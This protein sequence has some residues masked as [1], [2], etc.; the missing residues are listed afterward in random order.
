MNHI[1]LK[2]KTILI[3]G[4]AGFIGANLVMKLIQTGEPMKIVGLDNMNDYYDVSLKEYRLAEIEKLIAENEQVDWWFIKGDLADKE[5]IDSTFEDYQFDIV[6]NLAA[7][8]GVRYSITNPDAYINSNIIGFYN[9]L[10]AIRRFRSQQMIRWTTRFR[11]M[12]QR[13]RAM[14]FWR[15]HIPN[16]I[17]S[18]LPDC[19][20]SR[21]TVLLDVR[22]WLTLASLTS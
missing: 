21:Y 9:I 4:A 19:V 14:N 17:I 18:R 8:A 7:Q 6:V 5:L 13:K 20:S 2:T 11:S 1:E 22:I 12:Q 15:I 3:T 16:S 10:E